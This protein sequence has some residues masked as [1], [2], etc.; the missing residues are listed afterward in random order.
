MDYESMDDESSHRKTSDQMAECK[1]APVAVHFFSGFFLGEPL[2]GAEAGDIE[3]EG[4]QG[5]VFGRHVGRGKAIQS[6]PAG[7]RK[8]HARA[9]MLPGM[10]R[11]IGY[12]A[13]GRRGFFKSRISRDSTQE[14]SILHAGQP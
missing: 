12:N 11:T 9:R 13:R 8:P 10:L 6:F 4:F 7:R 2:G 1:T 5:P 14:V 3:T